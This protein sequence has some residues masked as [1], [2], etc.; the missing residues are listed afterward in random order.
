[1]KL[2]II[3]IC[4]EITENEF[5]SIKKNGLN[6]SD[7]FMGL[8]LYNSVKEVF[9]LSSLVKD[10]PINAPIT[11]NVNTKAKANKIKKIYKKYKL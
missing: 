2:L 4:C 1:M 6:V 7:L 8:K 5:S 11:N 9:P 3:K 10:Y